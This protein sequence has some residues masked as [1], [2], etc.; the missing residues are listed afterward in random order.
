[1]NNVYNYI[2]L[3]NK[4]VVLNMND[5]DLGSL[6]W[7]GDETA[8][9]FSD[10]ILPNTGIAYQS[11]CVRYNYC[12]G[13]YLKESMLNKTI[14]FNY[15]GRIYLRDDDYTSGTDLKSSL[16]GVPLIY[17]LATP[18]TIDVSDIL[19][20]D[21]V[22]GLLESGGTITFENDEKYNLPSDVNYLVEVE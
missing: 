12:L 9:F 20:N 7:N 18:V 19:D 16:S 11:I 13:V 17:E 2:D 22:I 3:E 10:Q 6:D 1:M 4:Q 5:V 21:D 15:D 14:G 8:N